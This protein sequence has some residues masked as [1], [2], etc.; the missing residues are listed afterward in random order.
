MEID[1]KNFEKEYKKIEND[2]LSS[3]FIAFDFEFS[4]M[5]DFVSHKPQIFF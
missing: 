3:D 1:I 2:I 4:G 5:Y